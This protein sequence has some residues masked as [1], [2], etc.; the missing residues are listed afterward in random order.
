M[1]KYILFFVLIRYIIQTVSNTY[2]EGT[3]RCSELLKLAKDA[4]LDSARN[5]YCFEAVQEDQLVTLE[6]LKKY[7]L[8]FLSTNAT[9]AYNSEVLEYACRLPWYISE[10][11]E[12]T[13]GVTPLSL[14]WIAMQIINW[15]L[16]HRPVDIKPL[17][18]P[19]SP[20]KPP[21]DRPPRGPKKPKPKP[22]PDGIRKRKEH[23]EEQNLMSN[24]SKLAN[25]SP[26][27]RNRIMGDNV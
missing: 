17:T 3:S 15:F 22:I 5:V 27:L 9:Y 11:L 13:S 14:V 6:T 8:G 19:P 12:W 21:M 25:L 18:P 10:T 23:K 20:D 26:K 7:K 16:D 4:E 1:I 24:L 2:L